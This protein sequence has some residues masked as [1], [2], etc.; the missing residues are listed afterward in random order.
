MST[1]IEIGLLKLKKQRD[2]I[3]DKLAEIEKVIENVEKAEEYIKKNTIFEGD[4][5]E[6]KVLKKYLE[7]GNVKKV[8]D[9]ISELGYRI[10]TEYK[11]GNTSERKYIASDISSIITNTD[12]NVDKEL[13]EFALMIYEMNYTAMEKMWV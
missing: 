2:K 11:N 3:N 9:Y 12:L 1:S 6:T 4:P 7:L 10:T 8:A 5:L 13:Q